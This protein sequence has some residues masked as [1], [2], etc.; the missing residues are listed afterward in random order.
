MRLRPGLT[1]LEIV[2]VL[3]LVAVLTGLTA[4]F[5]SQA[6][7]NAEFDRARETIRNELVAAQSDTIGGTNDS[8]WGVAFTSSTLTRYRGA[9]YATRDTSFD[10]V[11]TF[12]SNVTIS[13]TTD[14]PFT[15]PSGIPSASATIVISSD[16]LHATTTIN[17]AG[18]ISIQ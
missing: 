5:S 3:G 14:I 12:N 15:R 1:L 13:G 7:R 8:A 9:S 4:I 18:L 16:T 11:T 2:I 17:P 6:L 10:R